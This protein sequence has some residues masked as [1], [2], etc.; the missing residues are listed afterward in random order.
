MRPILPMALVFLLG[1]D[2]ALACG[3]K[4]LYL[5]RGLSFAGIHV[6][7][8]PASILIYM[9]ASSELPA[10]D[11]DVQLQTLLRLAGHRPKSVESR[12]EFEQAL[13]S[14]SYN[15]IIVGIS[16]AGTLKAA[17]EG[18]PGRPLLIPLLYKPKKEQ[19]AAAQQQ[20]SC[21]VKAEKNNRI[22]RVLEE[23]MK[24]ESKGTS[25]VCRTS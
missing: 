23:A 16:D 5:G 4:L 21:A 22:L 19:F 15:V 17:V 24:G 13:T 11:K 7:K 8:R 2:S 25:P 6:A 10:A 1:L 20:F 3:D 18:A 12:T 9:N 14:G